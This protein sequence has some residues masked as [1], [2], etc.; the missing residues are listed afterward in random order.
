MSIKRIVAIKV[1][2]KSWFLTLIIG[3]ALGGAA[4]ALG[5]RAIAMPRIAPPPASSEIQAYGFAVS[6]DRSPRREAAGHLIEGSRGAVGTRSP[7]ARA[8]SR[9]RRSATSS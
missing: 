6:D 9:R 7:P 1:E 3:L 8:D 5:L 2:G 4:F